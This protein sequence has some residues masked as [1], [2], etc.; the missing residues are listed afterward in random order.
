MYCKIVSC[1]HLQLVIVTVGDISMG[2]QDARMIHTKI[3]KD[4]ETC[5]RQCSD[6]K[7]IYKYV[8]IK[9]H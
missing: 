8:C 4:T 2:L 9:F 7:S 6:V 3:M 5:I 1:N